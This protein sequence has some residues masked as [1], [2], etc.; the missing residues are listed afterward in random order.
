MPSYVTPKK[1]VEFIFY[2]GLVSQGDTKTF[3]SNPTLASGDFKVSIDGGSLNNLTTLPAVTPA[4]SKLVKVTVSSSEMNGDNI[5]VIGSDAAGAEWCDIII[6]IQTTARQ[7]DDLAY[8]ATSGRSTLVAA[9]G[10]VSPNWADV[11]SPTTTVDLSGTTIKTTQVVG[12]VTGAVG[13]VT[14]AVGSVTGAVGSVSGNVGGNL[15]GN[16]VGNVNGNVV[17]SVGSV[18]GNVGGNVSGNVNGSVAGDLG[19]D[20]LGDVQGNVLGS[21]DSVVDP[22]T[23]TTADQDASA[24]ALLARNIAGGSSA[25][26]TV[27]EALAPLRNRVEVTAGGSVVVYAEDDTT[28][29]WTGTATRTAGANP[30]TQVDP[31]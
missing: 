4:S 13:S 26:R 28:P 17:G 31:S 2:V 19:G 10:S 5:Q 7:V 15:G 9:D 6:N 30:L 18:A 21:V 11:K 27:S 14:G 29:V 1:N 20:V 12:S 16:V 25:G 8:P 22:V 23:T 24:D 3:Q